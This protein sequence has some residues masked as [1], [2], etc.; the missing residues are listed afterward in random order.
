M[1]TFRPKKQKFTPLRVLV[2][3]VLFMLWFILISPA[4]A[5]TG[6]G[7]FIIK[8]KNSVELSSAPSLRRLEKEGEF[9][10]DVMSRNNVDAVWLR[11]GSVGTH[12]M[13]WGSSVRNTDQQAILNRIFIK[14]DGGTFW[15]PNVVYME[16]KGV[17][18]LYFN[19]EVIKI[20]PKTSI[21]HEKHGS[22][23]VL[24]AAILANITLKHDLPSACT[25]AKIYIEKYLNSN[26]T[27][28]GYHYV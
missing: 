24:S 6:G 9:L 25:N 27:L 26:N 14:V 5:Q 19:G 2:T 4:N 22:G 18:E 20:L 8:L 17:D 10:A 23:C 11:A 13:R 1:L 16:M 15:S 21:I 28:I 12:V 7:Q 3:G